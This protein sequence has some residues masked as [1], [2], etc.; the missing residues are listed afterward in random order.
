MGA[1]ALAKHHYQNKQYKE[2]AKLFHQAYKLHPLPG[3]LFNAA[4]SEQRAFQLD[5]AE[6]HYREVL[7]LKDVDAETRKRAEFHLG[8]VKEIRKRLA[9]ERKQAEDAA[10]KRRKAASA[11]RRAEE[12]DKQ[13]E[14]KKAAEEGTAKGASAAPG[15]GWKG[16]VGFATAGVG[17]VAL[18][19]GVYLALDASSQNDALN[20]KLE[21]TDGSGKITGISKTEY[22]A[23]V[24]AINATNTN[25]RIAMG[26]GLVALSASAW[27]LLT[28]SASPAPDGAWLQVAPRKRM[29]LV[30]LRF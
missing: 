16:P 30:S 23:E 13:A 19:L 14:A 21:Q 12:A 9:Q 26:A 2:A 25:S 17:A 18:G 8:E 1:L 22:K 24:D 15:S 7:T 20:A 3:F 27:M 11:A 10:E 29:L 28:R 5:A 4:R 6:E